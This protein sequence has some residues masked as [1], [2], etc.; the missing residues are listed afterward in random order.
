[1]T[2]FSKKAIRNTFER[3]VLLALIALLIALLL[4]SIVNDMYAFVKPQGEVMLSV[5]APT[6]LYRLAK[7]LQKNGVIKNPTF[8]SVFIISKGREQR[9]EAFVGELELRQDMS[10]REIMLAF[11]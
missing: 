8:F 2:G 6:S 3:T 10:Y 11:S 4:I 9:L 1:M 5:E 7:Q